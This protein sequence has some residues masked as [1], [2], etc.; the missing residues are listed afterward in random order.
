MRFSGE[1]KQRGVVRPAQ[2]FA[3]QGSPKP[4]RSKATGSDSVVCK[5]KGTL[6]NGKEIRQLLQTR[7][8]P[9]RSRQWCDKGWNRRLQLMPGGSK[10]PLSFRLTAYGERGAG[11]EIQPDSAFDL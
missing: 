11:A 7:V 3:V 9:P 10:W 2:R 1:Q 8:N 6:I 4:R 5:Y